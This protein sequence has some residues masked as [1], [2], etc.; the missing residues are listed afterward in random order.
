M[1]AVAVRQAHAADLPVLKALANEF[2]AWLSRFDAEPAAV[3]P[4]RA[5]PLEALAFGPDRLCEVIVAELDGEVAGYLIYYFGIWI[6]SDIAPCLY[7]AD[8]FVREMHQRRGIGSAM[9]EHAREVA[10]QRGAR[11]LFWTV[12]SKNP[13]GQAFYRR[14]GAEPFDDE[15][16]MRWRI[17]PE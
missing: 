4:A 2:E 1:T 9:M 12:W 5:D 8:I 7:V 16:M 17:A 6:G 11:N 13:V 14:L 10:R 15:I 3:D